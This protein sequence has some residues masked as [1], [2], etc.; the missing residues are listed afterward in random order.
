MIVI[1]KVITAIMVIM[2]I[3]IIIIINTSIKRET[4]STRVNLPKRP[5][6][7]RNKRRKPILEFVVKSTYTNDP[8]TS[9]LND[10][11][12]FTSVYTLLFTSVYTLLF[13]S[14]Y[15]VLLTSVYTLFNIHDRSVNKSSK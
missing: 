4:Y 9:R 3:I 7:H 11:L 15:T 14:V 2:I 13:T 1:I 10:T 5:Q 6:Q 8:S 12:L